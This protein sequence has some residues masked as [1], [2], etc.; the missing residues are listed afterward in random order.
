MENRAVEYLFCNSYKIR[1]TSYII[2]NHVVMLN[3][4]S[5]HS[6][7]FLYQLPPLSQSIQRYSTGLPHL[8]ILLTVVKSFDSRGVH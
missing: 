1:P 5:H 2:D 6:H 7:I 4:T 3:I 8:K